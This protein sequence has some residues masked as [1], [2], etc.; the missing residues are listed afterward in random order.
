MALN[1]LIPMGFQSPDISGG[2]RNALVTADQLETN[3]TN[4]RFVDERIKTSE[5]ER[6]SR[7]R[8]LGAIRLDQFFKADDIPG[9][10]NYLEQR[11]KE[12]TDSGRDPST[13]TT[14]IKNM[15]QE[16]GE[17]NVAKARQLVEMAIDSGEKIG[18]IDSTKVGAQRIF[19]NGLIVQSQRGGRRV[20]GPEGNEL[21]GAEASEAII[22][23]NKFETQNQLE[24]SGARKKG[25]EAESARRELIERGRLAAESTAGLRRGL[26]LLQTIKT[27]G[28]NAVSLGLKNR[29]GV[30][31]G[32]E[33]E[34][35][36]SLAKAVLSQ[37]RETFGAQ[38][39][40]EEGRRL[41]R[42][43]AGIGKS[44]EGNIRILERTL[45]L[46]ER[47]ANRALKAAE[48][49]DLTGDAE[50]IRGLLEFRLGE[51]DS[52][53]GESGEAAAAGRRLT[54]NPETGKLE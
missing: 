7:S 24:R 10:I 49:A 3:E 6:E 26:E 39:T 43:E 27:G 33:A 44:T 2:V 1:P 32:D 53:L 45:E 50:D 18:L 51:K 20:F 41:E 5:Q 30:T 46:S 14:I 37:L 8:V 29:L 47:V 36:N 34:L 48:A 13:D 54:F 12:L 4:R 38:F 25:A 22:E 21:F 9:A 40:Q 52:F 19:D 15:L 23:A 35:T 16:G 28:V 42:I 31:S 11:E 17:E